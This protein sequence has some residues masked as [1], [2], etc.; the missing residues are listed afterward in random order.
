MRIRKAASPPG[1]AFWGRFWPES[2][3]PAFQESLSKGVDMPRTILWLGAFVCAGSL[4]SPAWGFRP[5][6]GLRNGQGTVVNT[7]VPAPPGTTIVNG[8]ITNGDTKGA[9]ADGCVGCRHG[10]FGGHVAGLGGKLESAK[11]RIN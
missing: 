1:L 2:D 10:I 8:E 7:D 5:F 3:N 11:Q 4:C 9:I 6:A